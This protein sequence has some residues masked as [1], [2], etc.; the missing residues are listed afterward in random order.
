MNTQMPIGIDDFKEV[1]EH[2]YFIDKTNFIQSLIDGHSKVTLLTRP[3]RFGKTLTMSM[4]DYFFSL[5]RKQESLHLFDDLQIS[6]CGTDYLK[7]RGQYPVLFM[8]FKGIQNDTWDLAFNAFQLVIQKEFQKH[9]YLLDSPE[10]APEE[11][12]LYIR[13][14]DNTATLA[15]YQISLLYLCEYLYR[16]YKIRPIILIDEYDAPIQNAYTH[17][18]YDTTI[19]YFRTFYNNTLKGNEFLN[20]AILTGVLRI[21]KES[22]F[23]GLNNLRTCSILDNTYADVMGFT[24]AEVA[25]MARDTHEE[26]ALP[27][28]KKWYDG[29][30][31]GN[32]D[33][34]NPWSVINFFAERTADDYWVNTSSNDIIQHMLQRNTRN[35]EKNL[36]TLLHGGTVAA[37]IREGLIYKDISQNKDGLY[38]LLLMTG[39]LT[40][41]KIPPFPMGAFASS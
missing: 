33:I 10:L 35:Q 9:R 15:E 14:L 19:S 30:R 26:K 8:T 40:A 38:T 25:K 39:Y 32:A 20:F 7:H 1:R 13:F 36:L 6:Q 21:A 29:Y 16:Y 12:Q 18:F 5:E 2:Y 3:R 41:V 11:K 17:G 31:F 27:V 28:L 4:L 22:I 37:I 23:S 24:K 34:Y